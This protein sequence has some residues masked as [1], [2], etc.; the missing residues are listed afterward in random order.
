MFPLA[1]KSIH[2]WL[3]PITGHWHADACGEH[4]IWC[5]QIIAYTFWNNV[6]HGRV[7]T[8][9][10]QHKGK[11]GCILLF[12]SWSRR[13][14]CSWQEI[15]RQSLHRAKQTRSRHAHWWCFHMCRCYVGGIGTSLYL[16]RYTD[17][18]WKS[19][20]K[21]WW[22]QDIHIGGFFENET[23]SILGLYSIL[24]KYLWIKMVF[25]FSCKRIS[26]ISRQLILALLFCCLFGCG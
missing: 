5:R 6:T 23:M 14:T 7:H 3:L 25:S 12:S 4:F 19:S 13:L 24:W 15:C 9:A 21:I 22:W 18:A 1:D 20:D 26:V 16:C 8:L 11:Y 2:V 10:A 17:S